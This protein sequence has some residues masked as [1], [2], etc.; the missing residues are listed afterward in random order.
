[1]FCYFLFS[2]YHIT[3]LQQSDK[4]INTRDGVVTVDSWWQHGDWATNGSV[5]TMLPAIYN[6]DYAITGS[7]HVVTV[8]SRW[9]VE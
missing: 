2:S 8:S 7:H 6:S 9:L 4:N 1:M 5:V 3:K